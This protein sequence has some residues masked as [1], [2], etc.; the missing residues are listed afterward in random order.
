[1]LF[2]IG[3]YALTA[4]LNLANAGLVCEKNGKFKVNEYE[5]TNVPH[6]YALGDI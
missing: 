1:V 3:R 4:G 2:A 6:I 5:Q